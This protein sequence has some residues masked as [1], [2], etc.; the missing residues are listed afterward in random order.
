MPVKERLMKLGNRIK[1]AREAKQLTQNELVK[2][3]GV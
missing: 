2:L 1:E 3:R